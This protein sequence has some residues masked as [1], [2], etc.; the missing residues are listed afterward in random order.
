[1]G[2]MRYL[3]PGSARIASPPPDSLSS[4][5]FHHVRPS[6]G[7][8]R[9]IQDILERPG[10]YLLQCITRFIWIGRHVKVVSAIDRR[11]KVGTER[12]R[13]SRSMRDF[14]TLFQIVDH[15]VLV[16]ITHGQPVMEVMPLGMIDI[17]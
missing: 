4:V 15:Q 11:L 10:Y 8:P 2:P 9:A 16:E 7:S 6:L 1:M 12:V 14:P 17:L 5:L 13:R 3:P